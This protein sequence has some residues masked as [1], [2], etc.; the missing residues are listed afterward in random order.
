MKSLA[1]GP[2]RRVTF[3]TTLTTRPAWVP[4]EDRVAYVSNQGQA[5][6]VL[7]EGYSAGVS[8]P[9]AVVNW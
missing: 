9:T 8:V 6:L 2:W 7:A 5:E 4:G 1:G 3:E